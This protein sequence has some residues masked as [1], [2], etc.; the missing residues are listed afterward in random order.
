MTHELT[1]FGGV[2]LQ[3]DMVRR[4]ALNQARSISVQL[5]DGVVVEIVAESGEQRDAMFLQIYHQLRATKTLIKHGLFYQ[6]TLQ[7]SS[8]ARL[9]PVILEL[10]PPR[11]LQ[12]DDEIINLARS[13]VDL[14]VGRTHPAVHGTPTKQEH[15]DV[16][17]FSL[18]IRTH[19]TTNQMCKNDVTRQRVWHFKAVSAE[20][21]TLWL[22]R[23]HTFL[24]DQRV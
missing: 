20:T 15:D 1:T 14:Y 2:A 13:Q 23:L 4:L 12:I 24:L 5:K 21:R 11:T 16:L 17:L 6:W 3:L 19:T 8:H 18:E 22:K 10:Q 9:D 7:S